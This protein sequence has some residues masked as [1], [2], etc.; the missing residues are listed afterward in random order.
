LEK[1]LIFLIEISGAG[2]YWG[3]HNGPGRGFS[4]VCEFCDNLL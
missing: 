3:R 2:S 4:H 1:Y